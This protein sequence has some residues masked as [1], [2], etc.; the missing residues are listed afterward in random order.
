LSSS[1]HAPKNLPAVKG[2]L[3]YDDLKV[4]YYE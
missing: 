4:T 2:Y 3:L 1:V